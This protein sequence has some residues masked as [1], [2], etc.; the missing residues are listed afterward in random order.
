[1]KK[2]DLELELAKHFTENVE[3]L[4]GNENPKL[5]PRMAIDVMYQ[6]TIGICK[7]AEKGVDR[8]QP[9]GYHIEGFGDA[10]GEQKE[11]LM[12]IME[13]QMVH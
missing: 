3:H 12:P 6:V 8:F 2:T 7:I 4:N 13:V 10:E 9:M 11:M 5:H 1:M